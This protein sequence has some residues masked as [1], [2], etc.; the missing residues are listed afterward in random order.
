MLIIFSS[1]NYLLYIWNYFSCFSL[2]L[3]V[4][5]ITVLK[6]LKWLF[7]NI[8]D[9]FQSFE[10]KKNIHLS[11]FLNFYSA[12]LIYFWQN[13]MNGIKIIGFN[14]KYFF[15][16]W[17]VLYNNCSK[18]IICHEESDVLTKCKKIYLFFSLSVQI[19]RL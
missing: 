10:E 4:F 7:F 17:R 1:Q 12:Y 2:S 18:Q 6:Y 3:V 11:S 9:R 13:Y 8:F 16:W 15:H 14:L 5:L 19:H